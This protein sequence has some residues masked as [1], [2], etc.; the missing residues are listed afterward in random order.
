MTD[1]ITGSTPLGALEPAT[2]QSDPRSTRRRRLVLGART[3]LVMILVAALVVLCLGMAALLLVDPPEVSGWLRYAFGMAFGHIA[4]RI[5]AILGIPSAIGLWAM[6]GAAE[7]EAVPALSPLAGRVI[8]GGAVVVLVGLAIV[9]LVGG[10]GITIL[11]V[12][13][14]GLCSLLTLGLAGAAAFGPYR[15]RA[16]LSA[17]ALGLIVAGIL[18]FVARIL[19]MPST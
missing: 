2:A 6:A 1:Q 12:A 13:F 9:V 3:G 16:L 14:L 7:P 5:A 15:G 4:L 11:D 10:R 19:G 8:A 18:W 17:V